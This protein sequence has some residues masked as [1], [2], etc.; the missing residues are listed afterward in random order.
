MEVVFK[1]TFVRQFNKLEDLVQEEVL[2]VVELLK[3]KK[4]YKQLR[5]HKLRGRLKD[6]YSCSVTYN[7]RLVF[8]YETKQRIAVLSV[9]THDVY[10]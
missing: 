1:P 5:V 8:I 7:H 2:K 9:G 3:D 10:R 4:Y 6:C